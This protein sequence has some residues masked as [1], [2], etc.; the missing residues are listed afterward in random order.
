VPQCAGFNREISQTSWGF[1]GGVSWPALQESG[2]LD[3]IG[4]QL[5]ASRS[6]G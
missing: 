6:I 4:K 2:F 5:C 1:R 3:R